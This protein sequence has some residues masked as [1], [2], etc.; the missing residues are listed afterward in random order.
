MSYD[1]NIGDESFN[2]TYNVS[3]MWYACYP[4]KGIRK[5]YGLSGKESVPVLRKLREYMEN[6]YISLVEIEPDN[7]WGSYEGAVQ[8]VGRL[9]LAGIRNP[10][11]IWEGD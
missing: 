11:E 5:H 3:K 7:G 1:L 10:N 2:Y 6:N 9:I 4:D 8:F